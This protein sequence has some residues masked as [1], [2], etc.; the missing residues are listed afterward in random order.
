MVVW[1]PSLI[2]QKVEIN[3]GPDQISQNDTW[4]IAVAVHDAALKTYDNFPDIKGFRKG[5]TS[6]RYFTSSI[7]GKV[8]STES[9][10]MSYFPLKTGVITVNGFG[11]KVNDKYV[12]VAGKKV[13]V[14]AMGQYKNP[15]N[16]YQTPDDFFGEEEPDFVD[17]KDDAFLMLTT[18]KSE[19]YVGEGVNA[20]LSF[21][22]AESNVSSLRWHDLSKQLT[23]IIKILKPTTCWEEN[24]N[25]ENVEGEYATVNGKTYIRYKIYQATFYPFN[26]QAIK[27]PSVSLDMIKMKVARNPSLFR[28]NTLEGFKTYKSKEVDVKVKDLPPHPLKNTVVVGDFKL[29]EHLMNEQLQT[30]Q[31]VAYEFNISGEWNVSSI[32]KPNVKND[33]SFEIYEPNSTQEIGKSRN[34]VFGTKSFRYFMIPREPGQYKLAPYFQWIYFSPTRKVYDTLRSALAVNIKG[35]SKKNEVVESNDP[36]SFY[37]QIEFADNSLHKTHHQHWENWVFNGFLLFMVGI[38]AFL[39]FKK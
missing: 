26:N 10:V 19:V 22:M 6:T 25:I 2:A 27:F 29:N 37:D 15:N 39:L 38:S 5:G 16:S 4:T 12:K 11:M 20:V 36:G 34:K 14:R 18:D 7:N 13:T 31:S 21:Y 3:L 1:A 32:A 9:V 23:E 8:S 33:G 35:A 17:V 24:F 30:G 28:A